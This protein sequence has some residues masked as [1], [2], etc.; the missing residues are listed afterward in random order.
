VK[1]AVIGNGYWGKNLVR[2]FH[3]LGVLATVCDGNPLAGLEIAAKYPGIAF[4]TDYNQVLHDPAID[5]VV[6]ATPA[7]TH[8][9]MAKEALEC[10]KD[11][12]AEKPLALRESEGAQLVELADRRKRILMVGH[13]LQYHPAVRK[14]K[15][16]ITAGTLGRI[17]Y[18]YSNRLNIGK[19]RTE[20][21]I[22]WSFAP[23]DISVT[24]GLLDELPTEVHCSGGTYLSQNVADVTL[25][26]LTFPS[27]VRAHIFVSWLHPFKEQ[28][29]VVVGSEKMAVFNDMD[30]NKLQLYSHKL[31]WK[32]RTPVA[33]KGDA[34]VVLLDNYEPLREECNHFIEC[35]RSRRTPVTDGREGVRVLRVLNA[36]Q[37]SLESSRPV[38]LGT[39]V[40]VAPAKTQAFSAHPSAVVGEGANIGSGT[41]IW[42]FSHVMRGATIGQNCSF[43]QNTHVAEDVIVGDNVKVQNNVSLYA[44]TLVESDV[45]LGPSCVF[46]NVTNPRSQVNRRSLYERT[47]I[48]RGATVGANATIVCGTEIGQY[49]FVA[50]GAVITKNV[51]DYALV[52]GVPARQ[53]GWMSRHGH[54]LSEPDSQGLMYCPES[55]LAYRETEP[56]T[57]RCVDLDENSLLPAHLALGTKTYDEYKQ[58]ARENAGA[59][60]YEYSAS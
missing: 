14:L 38:S 17:E 54:R 37:Q 53:I 30:P 9:R 40:P 55:G 16:L 58:I 42:H 28:R 26:A 19:I 23:H 48:R 41:K 52:A 1:I 13:I 59:K 8:Y 4:T 60:D 34:E 24:L 22:L 18:L 35:V 47:L 5:A 29:I 7:V 46:T 12:Y 27:G 21:N 49:A 45:F 25:S 6:L 50:A 36:C 39:P 10:D 56:G 57:L 20:E 11:V 51:P 3:D 43:G 32:S 33:V 31:E 15:Q 2:N 44:G